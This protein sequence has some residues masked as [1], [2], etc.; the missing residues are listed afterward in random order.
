MLK[1]PCRRRVSLN[2]RL[3]TPIVNQAAPQAEQARQWHGFQPARGTGFQPAN[4][5]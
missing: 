2:I 4:L 1:Q 5:V 3:T